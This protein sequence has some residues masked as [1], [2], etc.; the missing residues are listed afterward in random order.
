MRIIIVLIYN[1]GIDLNPLDSGVQK[2]TLKNNG[3]AKL[4][5]KFF[6]LGPGLA[7]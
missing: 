6:S 7:A 3:S 1:L 5:V 2:V 4:R